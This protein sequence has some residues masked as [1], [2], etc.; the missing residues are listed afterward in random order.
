MESI[1]FCTTKTADGNFSSSAVE[2]IKL[3]TINA[4]TEQVETYVAFKIA[5]FIDSYWFPVLI[6]IDRSGW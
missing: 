6:P 3:T 1:T 2:N 4:F 5:N